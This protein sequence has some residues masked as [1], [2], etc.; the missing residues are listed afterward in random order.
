[1]QRWF[2][3][4]FDDVLNGS[5]SIIQAASCVA[6][7]PPDGA[8]A[9]EQNGEK[10]VWDI[11]RQ[12]NADIANSLRW[13]VWAKTKDGQKNRNRPRMIEQPKESKEKLRVYDI[14]TMD[15]VLGRKRDCKTQGNRH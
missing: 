13:L 15:E 4:D 3:I 1:M 6:Y 10:V 8:V 7:L 9:F 11:D 14:E 12:I 2:S 5:V